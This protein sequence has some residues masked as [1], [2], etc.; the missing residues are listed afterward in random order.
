MIFTFSFSAKSFRLLCTVQAPKNTV[1]S[2][3]FSWRRLLVPILITLGVT[4][5]LLHLLSKLDYSQ[6][7]EFTFTKHVFYTLCLALL[8]VLVR[9]AAYVY[10]IWELSD[11]KLSLWKSIEVILLWEFGSSITPA[12]FGGVS[13]AFFILYKEGIKAGKATSMLMLCSYLDNVAFIVVFSALY[14][15]FGNA[16]FDLSASCGELNQ[17]SAVEAFRAVGGYVWIGFL[18]VAF[19]G[20]LLGFSIFIRPN[21]ASAVLRKI[22]KQKWLHKWQSSII[23]V[24]NDLYLTSIEFK[25]RGIG[26]VIRTLI[27][28]IISWCARYALANVL[29]SGFAADNIH[30]LEVFAR[31]YV[32]RVIV[33]IP[34]TPGGS[35]I[36]ELSFM[37][38]NCEFVKD[39]LIPVVTLIWRGFNFYLYI[40]LGALIIPG[41]LMRVNSKKTNG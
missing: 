10:R 7:T 13:L 11:R 15:F 2:S 4:A 38:L 22:A 27:A 19:F 12:S 28:T 6:L 3:F 36:Q 5:Y 20:T 34:T 33:M 40:L 18:A 39:N 29:I 24:S 30:Q 35:G 14:L 21:Y 41:W 25:K 23:Q 26:F 1:V 9:D 17:L 37:A 16:M 32:H 8:T 31:Q